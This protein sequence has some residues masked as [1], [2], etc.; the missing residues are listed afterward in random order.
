MIPINSCFMSVYEW[1]W[2]ITCSYLFI[3]FCSLFTKDARMRLL[4]EEGGR[5]ATTVKLFLIGHPSAGKTTL[6]K[7]LSRVIY[8]N[9]LFYTTTITP[10]LFCLTVTLP[11]CTPT[12]D[13]SAKIE[14]AWTRRMCVLACTYV[15]VRRNENGVHY[16]KFL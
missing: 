9:W 11:T 8:S 14:I 7:S 6:K 5:P 2:N 15:T 1:Y 10:F 4:M 16:L 13:S 3:Y 12:S